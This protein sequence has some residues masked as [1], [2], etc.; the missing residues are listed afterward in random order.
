M[1]KQWLN[2]TAVCTL[3]EHTRH[4]LICYNIQLY[5]PFERDMFEV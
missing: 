3:E 1:K 4:L 5:E 2:I